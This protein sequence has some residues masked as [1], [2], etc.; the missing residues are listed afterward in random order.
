MWSERSAAPILVNP[1]GHALSAGNPATGS[2]SAPVWAHAL[3]HTMEVHPT[4][5]A[6]QTLPVFQ[7]LGLA[8]A[9][10]QGLPSLSRSPG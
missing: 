5:A 8:E 10:T 3:C 7:L 6:L 4:S 9:Q 2:W 1:P